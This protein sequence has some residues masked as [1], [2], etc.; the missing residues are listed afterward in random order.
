MKNATRIFAGTCTIDYEGEA[1]THQ[2]G[3]VLT[4]VKPD[5]TV[6]VH[7]AAGYQPA[8]WLTR[9]ET[10]E[11]TR[12]G[13]GFE[14]LATAGDQR[15]SVESIDHHDDAQYQISP[16]GVSVGSCPAC[17]GILV[18]TGGAVVCIGC[19]TRWPLQHDATLSETCCSTCGLPTMILRRGV[20][21]HVCLD[22]SC[23]SLASRVSDRFD[24]RWSCPTCGEAMEIERSGQFYLVCS[25]CERRHTVPSGLI[26]GRC[27]CGLP[28]FETS[29][30]E[31]CLDTDCDRVADEAAGDAAP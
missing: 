30:T 29:R 1:E 9:P 10:V 14:I 28:R 21:F 13:E 16:A 15:L 6:L 27:S 19:L 12:D 23:D 5:N 3:T 18:R 25:A 11:I 31:Q 17:A 24:G 22:D 4:I 2:H 8:A 20:E 26:V 7:D